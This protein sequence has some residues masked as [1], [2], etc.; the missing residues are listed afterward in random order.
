MRTPKLAAALLAVSAGLVL[1]ACA[2]PTETPAPSDVTATPGIPEALHF[3]TTT[4]DG[5]PFDGTSLYG[6]STILWF[7]APWC[8]SC[9][10]D[11]KYILAAIPDLPP[12]VQIVGV[13]TFASLDD[14]HL[15]ADTHGINQL[16]NIVDADGAIARGFN[17]PE[18]PSAGVLYQDGYIATIPGSLST[19][20]VLEIAAKI[21]P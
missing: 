4:L 12:G 2:S 17:L 5:E 11:A 14:M 18:L 10:A 19:E 7:W 3:T 8:G 15:F 9:N 20:R 13:P 21:A 6:H 16:T 1:A